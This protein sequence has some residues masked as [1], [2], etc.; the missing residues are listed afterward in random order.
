MC[1]FSVTKVVLFPVT[2]AELSLPRPLPR[3]LARDLDWERDFLECL[4]LGFLDTRMEELES[5]S[6][7]LASAPFCLKKIF[8]FC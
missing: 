5:N 2:E 8:Y 1:K 6:S 7:E 4:V 3:P